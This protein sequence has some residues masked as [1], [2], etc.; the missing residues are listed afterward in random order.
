MKR[1]IHIFDGT[2]GFHWFNKGYQ[3]GEKQM[4]LVRQ[5]NS[6]KAIQ[7]QANPHCSW[8]R[9]FIRTATV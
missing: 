6:E 1:I 2:V 4:L 9:K 8:S 3:E 5:E 7:N